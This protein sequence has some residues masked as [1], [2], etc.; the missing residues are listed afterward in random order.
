MSGKRTILAAAIGLLAL[1]LQLA[2]VGSLT[3]EDQA[4]LVD[5]VLQT[6]ELVSLLGAIWYRLKA[7]KP[8]ALAPKAPATPAPE[9]AG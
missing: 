9:D 3:T 1:T 5:G 8:G 7:T 6:L 4:H 2:G